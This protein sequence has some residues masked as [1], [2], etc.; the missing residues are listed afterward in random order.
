M[1]VCHIQDVHIHHYDRHSN[2]IHDDVY[3][4][5]DVYVLIV[6]FDFYQNYLNILKK[7]FMLFRNY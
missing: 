2:N 5:D 4:D 3:G 1:L 6:H 7:N